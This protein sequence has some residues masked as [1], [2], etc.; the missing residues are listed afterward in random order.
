MI[1]IHWRLFQ[2]RKPGHYYFDLG[3]GPTGECD[4]S[5]HTLSALGEPLISPSHS[6]TGCGSGCRPEG[7]PATAGGTARRFRLSACG[8]LCGGVLQ[9]TGKLPCAGQQSLGRPEAAACARVAP[10]SDR[11]REVEAA[12]VRRHSSFSFFHRKNVDTADNELAL[13]IYFGGKP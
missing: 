2:Q 5:T 8:E 12:S 10:E 7:L 1:N 13:F 9:E 11:E 6:Q 3:E 4:A